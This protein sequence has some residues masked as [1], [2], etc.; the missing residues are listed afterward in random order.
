MLASVGEPSGWSRLPA[1]DDREDGDE[2]EREPTSGS[3]RAGDVTDIASRLG[4]GLERATRE[5]A[6]EAG[7]D[8]EGLLGEADLPEI[9]RDDPLA[10]M[11]LRLDRE[12]D[13]WRRLAM[14]ALA[15]SRAA[16]RVAYLAAGVALLGAVALGVVAGLG[17]L[18]GVEDP[19]GRALLVAT[20]VATVC[21]GAGCVVLLTRSVR[22]SQGEVRRAALARADLA[23]LRLH[24]LGVVLAL[25]DH[26]DDAARAALARLERDVSAPAR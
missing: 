12:A 23:E 2:G 9:G 26:D 1:E 14:R 7:S 10:A 18:F 6:A 22:R 21:A 20:G 17:A 13:L 5:L 8:L 19:G 16:D 25:R 3:S 24:R 15:R 4:A 11:A